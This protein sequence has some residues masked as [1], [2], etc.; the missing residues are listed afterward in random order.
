MYPEVIHSIGM[1]IV[2]CVVSALIPHQW[3]TTQK[4]MRPRVYHLL[5]GLIFGALGIAVMVT[6][7]TSSLGIRFDTRSVVLCVAG[8]VGGPVIAG[9]A[10]LLCAFYWLLFG[11]VGVLVGICV[12]AQSACFGSVY[13]YL[14]RHN[15]RLNGVLPLWA[16]GVLVQGSMLVLMLI[17]AGDIDLQIFTRISIPLLLLFPIAIMIVCRIFF[18]FQ[19][20]RKSEDALRLSEYKYRELVEMSGSIIVRWKLDGTITYVNEGACVLFG[21][22]RE[23]L[24]GQTIPGISLFENK[25]SWNSSH[26]VVQQ[27]QEHLHDVG[28]HEREHVR[29]DGTRTWVDWTG[30]SICDNSGVV[31]EILSIGVDC[32]S[33]KN[34]EQDFSR[35]EQKYRKLFE[36]MSQ[37]FFYQT[38]DGTLTDVNPSALKMLGLTSK[39]FLGRTSCSPVWNVIGEDGLRLSPEEHPSMVALRT[40]ETVSDSMIGIFN[41]SRQKYA[42]FNV[43]AVP[44]FNPDEADPCEVFVTLHDMSSYH[45]AQES[46]LASEQQVSS[47]LK[48][49]QQGRRALLSILE[50]EH[51]IQSSLQQSEEQ[52]RSVIETATDAI[53]TINTFGMIVLWNKAAT[54]IFGFDNP[55][56][57]GAPFSKLIAH[58]VLD[59]DVR[60]LL[61]AL[62]TGVLPSPLNVH[63]VVALNKKGTEFPI[64]IAFGLVTKDQDKHI[65]IIVRD[66]TERKL[67]E[68]E[69]LRSAQLVSIGELAAGV[70]HEINNPIMG[71]INYAQILLNNNSIQGSDI[72]IPARIIKEGERIA[73]IVSNLL[74]LARPAG[75]TVVAVSVSDIFEPVFQLMQKRISQSDIVVDAHFCDN[76]PCVLV[77]PQKIQQVFINLLS[78]AIFALDLRFPDSHADKRLEVRVEELYVMNQNFLR[79][80]FLD[81]GCGISSENISRICNPFFSTKPLGKGTGL[82]LSI[83]HDIIKQ[84]GG[85]LLFESELG[86]YTR[87]MVDLPAEVKEES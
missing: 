38:A 74:N 19:D 58:S 70:A 78:N 67:I 42:W 52:Y 31:V 32:T 76:Q 40:G 26:P 47:L 50:D 85:R 45:Q 64:D 36:N 73:G 43:N 11:E 49:A 79:V 7:Q 34:M 80:I 84:H 4:T 17:L 81:R 3:I 39:E 35:S 48:E 54:N 24:L 44:Q 9:V 27:I 57:I 60:S 13:Y 23:K 41:E 71:V 18:E 69:A 5:S 86:E 21:L 30:K 16:F 29:S 63:E 37:G 8:V 28:C 51:E 62:K 66:I 68:Q 12:I 87:V 77:I 82:G 55:E 61:D 14:R 25:E 75:E 46:L 6:V 1:L 2:I 72:E 53:I 56:I 65:T 59:Q 83:C 20:K 33:R 15:P 22:S 10:A